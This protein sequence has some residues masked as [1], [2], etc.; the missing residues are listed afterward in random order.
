MRAIGIRGYGDIERVEVLDLPAP[1]PGAGEVVVRM[2]AA[3]LNHL[4][5]WTISGSLGF[6]IDFPFV[7]GADGAGEIHA[8]GAGVDGL[9]AGMRVLV[10][11]VI[12]CGRCEQCLA[13]QQSRCVSMRMLG[14]HLP[15]TFTELLRV[16]ARNVFLCPDHLS[17]AEAAS[18]GVTFITAYRMLFTQGEMKPGDSV[19]ITG[20]G[21]GL[22]LSALQLARP[23]AGR[24]YVTSS[25]ELKLD[26]AR[27]LGA[28]G[29]INYR[30]QDVGKEVRRL[31]SKRGVDVVIDS[32]GGPSLDESLRAL[33]QGGRVVVAGATAG[34]R[35]QIDVRRLF[36]NQLRIIGSTMGSHAD[37]A[38]MLRLVAGAKLKPI[39][40]RAFPF[41]Q[42][43]EALRYLNSQDRFGKVVLDLR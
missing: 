26:R 16:P 33:T 19:L 22:A 1:E 10:D 14:E 3:A 30:D 5:L 9:R 41:S 25:S 40:D 38:G 36:W 20:I 21:G 12:S 2:R 7:L 37:V 28:D 35:A 17:L 6:D 4:D 42:A 27:Q 34:R 13:G 8:V 11:P 31:T 39:V 15:G 23:V 18:L 24:I 32:A 29:G 43:Q